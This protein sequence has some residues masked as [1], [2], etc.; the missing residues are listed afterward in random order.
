[1]SDAI[2]LRIY[3]APS[4]QW[5]GKLVDSTGEEIGGIAGCESSQDVEQKAYD[6]GIYPDLIEVEAPK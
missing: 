5:S 4:G 3:R 2:T 6:S 1:M